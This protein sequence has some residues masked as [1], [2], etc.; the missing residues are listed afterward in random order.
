VA[1]GG[2]YSEGRIVVQDDLLFTT[3]G[4][5]LIV[6]I[7]D[8]A[9]PQVVGTYD[10][11]SY[12]YSVNVLGNYAYVATER[13]GIR[14]VDVSDPANPVEVGFADPGD[15]MRD[16]AFRNGIAFTA[17]GEAGVTAIQNDLAT[18]AEE[19]DEVPSRIVLHQN[20]P[21]PFNPSTTIHFELRQ[22]GEVTITVYNMLGQH[23]KTLLQ[24]SR[25]AGQ[26]A[27]S[28]DASGLGSGTYLY[29]IQS[30][31]QQVARQMILVK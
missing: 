27:V 6:D 18:A 1:T 17:N 14:L 19:L 8:K 7:S 22:A 4:D 24:A 21:N 3:N 9:N 30:G 28:F 20:Y 13:E 5:L 15:Q 25:T 31:G 11:P 10:A 26:H 16:V 2:D 23:V 29:Q 12:S